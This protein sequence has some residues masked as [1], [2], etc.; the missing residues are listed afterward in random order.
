MLNFVEDI[1]P[2]YP[3]NLD[4][5]AAMATEIIIYNMAAVSAINQ[6]RKHKIYGLTF[7]ALRTLI[8]SFTDFKEM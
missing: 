7:S 2:V 1:M 6:I 3:F 5:L 4:R 8:S